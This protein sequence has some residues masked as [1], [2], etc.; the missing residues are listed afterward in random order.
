MVARQSDAWA[1]KGFASLRIDFRGFGDRDGKLEDT[2]IEGQ[3][4]DALAPI[5]F[6]TP[7][8]Q[9]RSRDATAK[10]RAG[11]AVFGRSRGCGFGRAKTGARIL[12]NLRGWPTKRRRQPKYL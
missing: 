10:M 12:A 5:V 9:R 2:T 4:K 8:L 1:E 7:G 3:V 11:L 6:L